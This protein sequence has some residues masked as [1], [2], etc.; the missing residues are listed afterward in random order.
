M[1]H[2]PSFFMGLIQGA[3]SIWIGLTILGYYLAKRG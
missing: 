2:L 1:L 3:L